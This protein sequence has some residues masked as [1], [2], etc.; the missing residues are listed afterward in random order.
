MQRTKTRVFFFANF[1]IEDK[2]SIGGATVLAKRI[3]DFV[4][5]NPRLEVKHFQIRHF[6]RSK[7]QIIDYLFWIATFPFFIRKY[8]VVSFHVTRDFHF[9][10]APF[11]WFWSKLF[12]KKVLYHVF[13]GGF[14]R[15]Y[16][17]M[18][19]LLQIL[20]DKTYLKS[21]FF[22]VETLEMKQYLENKTNQNILWLP[23]SR[24]P[25][26]DA[27][28]S[29]PFQKKLVFF[30]RMV[31]DKGIPELI[32]TAQLLPDDYILDAYG[33]LDPNHYKSNPFENTKVNYKGTVAPDEVIE[34]LLQYDILLMP[35]YIK[36]EGYPG[37]IIEALS[38]GIPVIA[39]NCCVMSEMITDG[40]NG[41]LVK[42]KDARALTDAILRF[43]NE[44]YLTFRKNALE[45]FKQFNSDI[46]FQKIA[47]AYLDE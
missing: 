18:P 46:V 20:A 24:K 47:K 19:K 40:Y 43:N 28:L 15:Q 34:L 11:L 3:F 22:I 9:S 32:E 17:Q 6:W 25:V 4:K 29:K 31:P 2:R 39:T 38:A 33:P 26:K 7:F 30:S 42:I 45:S 41:F 36:R 8:D 5:T 10:V 21:D 35:T 27:N 14:H 1:P 12:N 23:N 44:N 16:E 13:G 37:I